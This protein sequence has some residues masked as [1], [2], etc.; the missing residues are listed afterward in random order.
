LSNVSATAQ[1]G[2]DPLSA[3]VCGKA[4]AL[5]TL[6]PVPKCWA[7][8]LRVYF[9]GRRLFPWLAKLMG[10][11]LQRLSFIHFARWTL[12][13]ELPADRGAS[14]EPWRYSQLLFESNFNGRWDEYIDAFA[15]T[16]GDRMSM[17]WGGAFGF[18]G[19]K[20]AEPFKRYIRARE[21]PAAHY[22]SAYPE[23]TATTIQSALELDARVDRFCAEAAEL[24]PAEF[25]ERFDMFRTDIQ[26]LV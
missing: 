14:A 4:Q 20:P 21:Y 15:Y 18:P 24:D 5:T 10:A 16:L 23:D 2:W 25:A 6:S 3:N 8:W 11:R 13:R 9:A 17:I 22:Y 26:Q 1:A 12:V 7:R 19:P